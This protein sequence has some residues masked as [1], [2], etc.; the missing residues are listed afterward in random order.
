EKKLELGRLNPRSKYGTNPTI[1]PVFSYGRASPNAGRHWIT[2]FDGKKPCLTKDSKSDL[3]HLL[4]SQPSSR[5]GSAAAPFPLL[6][7]LGAIRKSTDRF[8]RIHWLNSRRIEEQERVG[9]FRSG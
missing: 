9:R 7:F 5:V 6:D 1:S 4:D 8:T 3:E 2:D